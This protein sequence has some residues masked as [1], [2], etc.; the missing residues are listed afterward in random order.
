MS[1]QPVP[2]RAD[3]KPLP[4]F[5]FD[6]YDAREW[7]RFVSDWIV[8]SGRSRRTGE[9][10]ARN[11]RILVYRLGKPAHLITESEVRDFMLERHKDLG[12]S[13]RRIMY[14]GLSIL[15]NDILKYEWELLRAVRAKRPIIVPVVLTRAETDR[16]FRAATTQAIY[17]H[18]RTVYSCGFRMSEALSMRT[19]DIDRACGALHVRRGKG[20]KNRSVI[21]PAATLRMLGQYWRTHRNP[22]WI[23]P[24][25][26]HPSDVTE[27]VLL[28][29][30]SVSPRTAQLGTT[31]L[32]AFF[33]FLFLRGD[34]ATDLSSCVPTVAEWRC[35]TRPKSLEPRQV[36]RMLGCCDQNTAI[37]R[38]DYAALLLLSRLGFR[39]GEIVAMELDDI[40]W[41]AGVLRVR[42]KGSRRDQLPL[43]ED[44][45]QALAAYLCDGRPRCSTRRVFVRARAPH[46]GFSGSAAVDGIVSR[47]L[48]RAG[49]HPPRKG[50][51]LMRHSLAVRML[52]HGAS[53]DE[54]AE[55]LRHCLIT[56]TQIYAKVDVAALREVAQPWPGGDT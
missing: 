41:D 34:T 40:D 55:V 44:V 53:L 38:R 29:A 16:L 28:Y 2:V 1:P 48:T 10:Y 50:A 3:V 22:E 43:V 13:S 45:G 33:R 39:A 19:G 12:G 5:D 46:Q 32:R 52:R 6:L 18:L 4:A 37:G 42:G 15:F 26:L 25:E 20:D 54:I 47:A 51:H 27:F 11:V 21:L 23:F 17:T 9:A 14:R 31:V 8:L 36:E 35:S 7:F 24:N 49:L 56:T 30:R